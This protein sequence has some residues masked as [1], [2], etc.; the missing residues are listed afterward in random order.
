[1]REAIAHYLGNMN[2][3]DGWGIDD[4]LA[5]I[6]L[7]L[8]D[9]QRT[10]GVHGSLFE[11]GVH[12]GR[13]AIL[14]SLMARPAERCVFLDL[15][16][17]QDENIDNSGRGNLE[18][19]RANLARWAPGTAPEI[20]AGNSLNLEFSSIAGLVHGVRFAHIDGGH[21]KAVV[22][23]DLDKTE[24]VLGPGGIVVVD[25][26]LHS[27]FLGVN[28]ACNHYLREAGGRRLLPIA[29]GKNKLILAA[30]SHAQRY[31]DGLLAGLKPQ[32]QVAEFYGETLV[33][34]DRF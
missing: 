14:L 9:L 16:D 22:L 31:R 18:T 15:F 6:F 8:D 20:I 13:T 7:L 27:G 32:R 34:L 10:L 1:M 30:R 25:D 11:I 29:T 2:Q 26:F 21:Y 33:C 23:N 28:E 19:F 17:R 12:H 3:V 24:A 5:R 4:D